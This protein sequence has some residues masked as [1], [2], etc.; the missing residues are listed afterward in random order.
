MA[1][2]NSHHAKAIV[3][4]EVGENIRI[5]P[6]RPMSQCGR[7]VTATNIEDLFL[8]PILETDK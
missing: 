2:R 6:T 7:V 5:R 1:P 8:F 3:S 4:S